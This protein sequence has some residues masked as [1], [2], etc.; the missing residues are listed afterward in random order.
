MDPASNPKE[1]VWWRRGILKQ[2]LVLFTLA[3]TLLKY[4]AVYSVARGL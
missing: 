3:S 4:D 1:V 2:R